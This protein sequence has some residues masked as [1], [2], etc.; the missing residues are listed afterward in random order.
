[1]QNVGRDV[2]NARSSSGVLRRQQRRAKLRKATADNNKDTLADS[3]VATAFLPPP[4]IPLNVPADL[5]ND[6]VRAFNLDFI[7]R[8][9]WKG[10]VF[11]SVTSPMLYSILSSAIAIWLYNP[12]GFRGIDSTAHTVL[13]VLVSF[14]AV[15]RTQQAYSRYWEGR[16]HLGVLM[17]GIVEVASTAS[18]QLEDKESKAELGRLLK[19]YFRETVMFLRT[20]SR[21]TKRVSNYWLSDDVIASSLEEPE[22]CHIDADDEECAMLEQVPRPPI[23]VL[24]W[25]RAHLFTE[26]VDNGRLPG[27]TVSERAQILELGIGRAI[28]SMQAVFNGC[29]KI[30]TTPA[31]QPYTQMGRWLVF[32]FVYT[33]PFALLKAFSKDLLV[34]QGPPWIV[35]PAAMLLTFGYY[36]LDYCANQLQNPFIA[37]F[38]DVQLDGRFVQ[39]VCTD[40]DILL[41]VNEESEESEPYTP[42]DS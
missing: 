2:T 14:L 37:E 12:E 3:A 24:Q 36:G 15:F 19:L 7:P 22:E 32:W 8:V 13:G 27:A 21:S 4:L 1:M 41:G 35:M 39:A 17:A 33:V 42:S 10:T 5:E 18:V 23:V 38:G 31:P 11:P 26:G 30:A 9:G 29:A 28:A 16:G 34:T 25:I 6:K 20:A 40:V